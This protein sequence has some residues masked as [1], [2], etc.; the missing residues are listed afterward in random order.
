MG[1]GQWAVPLPQRSVSRENQEGDGVVA[2][3]QPAPDFTLYKDGATTMSLA[4]FRGQNLVLFFFPKAFTGTCERQ[5][6]EHAQ[7]N[8]QFKA[9]NAQIVGVSTDQAPTLAKF[10]ETCESAGKVTLL[11]DFR[12]Q[13]VK[14]YGVAVETGSLPNQRAV[15]VID[16]DGIVRYIHIEPAPSNFQGVEPEL[17]ALKQ[18]ER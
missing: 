2:V 8:D 5:V 7:A 1:R 14:A 17:A 10:A 12:R 16:R 15:F 9:L 4:D 18:I 13:A 6:S 11:S 3:G